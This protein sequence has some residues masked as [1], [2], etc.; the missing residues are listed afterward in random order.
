MIRDFLFFSILESKF[1]SPRFNLFKTIWLN[2]RTLP[3][4]QA[5]KLPILLYGSW[6]LRSLQGNII[7]NSSNLSSG[8]I[9]IG[10]N[11][12][13]YVTSGVST[14]TLLKGSKIYIDEKVRIAQGVSICLYEDAELRLGYNCHLGD[15][16]KI[17]CAK[18][19]S[20]GA[21]S[22]ITW[23]S[24]VMDHG[25]HYTFNK[26]ERKVSRIINPIVISD[27]CWVG[28]RTTIMPGTKLPPNTIVASNSLLN[29]D[30]VK[31]GLEEYCII[32]GQPARLIKNDYMR[33]YNRDNESFYNQYFKSSLDN[34]CVL[35]DESLKREMEFRNFIE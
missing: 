9:R 27:Y 32:G 31:S 13:G 8:I 35:S 23:E 15:S 30:Y 28:N 3:F 26:T 22:E 11:Y 2:F 5:C 6:N 4:N 10:L 19:V 14:L 29:K 33:V 1:C 12:A 17:I 34:T 24:Q 25:S 18:S 20:I 21:H 16:V 7:L